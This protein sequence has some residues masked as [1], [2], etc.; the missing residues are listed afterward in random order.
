MKVV[1]TLKIGSQTCRSYGLKQA[2]WGPQSLLGRR[3]VAVASLQVTYL[4]PKVD[5]LPLSETRWCWFHSKTWGIGA[6]PVKLPT[7]CWQMVNDKLRSTRVARC[8]EFRLHDFLL[9][10]FFATCNDA[11]SER[12]IP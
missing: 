12:T 1:P 4:H 3:S 8:H 2:I 9:V 5:P 10:R 11:S 6:Q 7:L